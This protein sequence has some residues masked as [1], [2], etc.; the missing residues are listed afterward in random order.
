MILVN[1][2]FIELHELRLKIWEKSKVP[3][4]SPRY[5]STGN[6]THKA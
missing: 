1:Y 6:K 2:D 3:F 5:S 4:N